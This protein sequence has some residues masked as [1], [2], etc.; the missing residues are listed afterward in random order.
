MNCPKCGSVDVNF[1][2]IRNTVKIYECNTCE[3]EFTLEALKKD[4]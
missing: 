1:L 3:L 4:K 2:K